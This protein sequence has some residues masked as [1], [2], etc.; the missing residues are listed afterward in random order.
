MRVVPCLTATAL[1]LSACALTSK[2][3][4]QAI[5]ILTDPPA[6]ACKVDRVGA[7]LADV[8]STP[9][10]IVIAR[11]SGDLLVTCSKPGYQT[12]TLLQ[13]PHLWRPHTGNLVVSRG[14]GAILDAATAGYYLYP[15]EV[16]L[17]LP[18]RTAG[19]TAV[20]Y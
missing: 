17:D 12:V 14:T 19:G 4:G 15:S 13:P 10:T 8:V 7:H 1:T 16:A 3:S 18:A 5:S 9:G 11:S 6:A 2:Q 20:P